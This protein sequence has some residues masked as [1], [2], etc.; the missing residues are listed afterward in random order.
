M[1]VT[2]LMTLVEQVGVTGCD[3][4]TLSRCLSPIK[5]R[6]TVRLYVDGSYAVH[7]G[8]LEMNRHPYHGRYDAHRVGTTGSNALC[9][10]ISSLQRYV[11]IEACT[12]FIDGVAPKRKTFERQRRSKRARRPRLS[13]EERSTAMDIMLASLNKLCNIHVRAVW[14]QRGEAEHACYT[15]RDITLPSIIYT[16]DTD[17]FPITC[18]HRPFNADDRVFIGRDKLNIFYEAGSVRPPHVPCLAWLVLMLCRGSDYTSP[19]FTPTMCRAVATMP[20]PVH[21]SERI[22]RHMNALQHMSDRAMDSD[23]YNADMLSTTLYHLLVIIA[24]RW[25]EKSTV[26][27]WNAVPANR[28]TVF[29]PGSYD[30]TIDELVWASNYMRHSTSYHRYD[31]EKPRGHVQPHSTYIGAFLAANCE[32]DPPTGNITL[33]TFTRF[34]QECVQ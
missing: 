5:A 19:L 26:V 3:A 29:V 13:C 28:P 27:S 4:A 31:D 2:A 20:P 30:E 34:V 23:E 1:G 16:S 25:M 32:R 12:V 7:I 24:L 18:M 22:R 11:D 15:Q 6:P 14:L 33:P 21:Q 8:C 10:R 9:S 17:M